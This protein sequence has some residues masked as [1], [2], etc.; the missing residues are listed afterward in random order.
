[1]REISTSPETP[2]N[3]KGS[4]DGA[5]CPAVVERVTADA[6]EF[7]KLAKG[8]Y[9]EWELVMKVNLE[10]MSLCNTVQSDSVGCRDDR[11][12]L[13]AILRLVP[14]EKKSSIAKKNSAKQTWTAVKT[15]R[16]GDEHVCAVNV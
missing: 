8:S 2:G 13:A 16:L 12:A 10:A 6:L 9:H 7:P 11:M 3:K 5:P 1:V 14:A 4:S 15:M